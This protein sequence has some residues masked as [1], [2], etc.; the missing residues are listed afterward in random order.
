MTN[1]SACDSRNLKLC[2]VYVAEHLEEKE[3]DGAHS[4]VNTLHLQIALSYHY[5][6]KNHHYPGPVLFSFLL[7]GFGALPY[8]YCYLSVMQTPHVNRIANLLLVYRS[9]AFKINTK[10]LTF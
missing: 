7:S 2:F 6:G 5:D 9:E 8:F 3:L 4:Q 1:V 10:L